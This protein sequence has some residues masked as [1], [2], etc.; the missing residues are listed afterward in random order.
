MK[1]Q[2]NLTGVPETMLWTLHNRACEALRPDGILHDDKAVNIYQS[3]EYDY[4]RS[5][6]QPDGSH[7]FRSQFFDHQIESFLKD[8]P[9]GVVINLGEGLETQRYR[10]NRK[11]SL[12]LS[13]D[14]PEA[15]EIRE[16]FIKP[17]EHYLHVGCSALDSEWMNQVPSN[18]AVL[19]T[20]QGLLMYFSEEQV[21]QFLCSLAERFPGAR[22]VFDY[23]PAWLSRKTLKGW[24]KSPSYVT[25]Q[26]P[27]GI[28]RDQLKPTL[29]KWV[30][31]LDDITLFYFQMP[32]GIWKYL[33]SVMPHVPVLK[34]IAPGIISLRFPHT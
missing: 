20:A 13:V 22:L 4:I 27:W 12:W 19:I 15:I 34:N 31:G 14:V 30:S 5:F 21:H 1:L 8:H 10:V 28:N 23:I 7:A 2:V 26:M 24:N 33:G 29:Q 18:K 17:D 11:D 9:D 16:R 6:G 25:P 32:R 3:L